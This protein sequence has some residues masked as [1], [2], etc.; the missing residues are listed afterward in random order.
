MNETLSFPNVVNN[1]PWECAKNSSLW[2]ITQHY[3]VCTARHTLQYQVEETVKLRLKH[4]AEF[5]QDEQAQI[6]AEARKAQIQQQ[7]RMKRR[8]DLPQLVNEEPMQYVNMFEAISE[9]FKETRPLRAKKKPPRVMTTSHVAASKISSCHFHV[10]VVNAWG[11]PVRKGKVRGKV[12][13]KGVLNPSV[14]IVM[15]GEPDE[16]DVA[17]GSSPN[18]DE[19]FVLDFV[20]DNNDFSSEN[21]RQC[22][23]YITFNIFDNKK[24][25]VLEDE[26]QRDSDEHYRHAKVWLGKVS[27]P[28]FT[29]LERGRIEGTFQ[30]QMPLTRLGYVSCSLRCYLHFS[31]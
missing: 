18:W 20:P 10:R 6:L 23:E 14:Q 16:T 9:V 17:F 13:G 11:L 3:F 5:V 29:L 31:V 26:R 22:H 21:L 2:S 25:D 30:I 4:V 15:Q 1:I 7:K 19:E 12:G 28:V 24:V 8:L 27:F